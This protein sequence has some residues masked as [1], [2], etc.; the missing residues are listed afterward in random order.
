MTVI[1]KHSDIT[2]K[3][4]I[5][6]C[7]IIGLAL[8]VFEWYHEAGA[9]VLLAVMGYFLSR[10]TGKRRTLFKIV[11][12]ATSLCV[13]VAINRWITHTIVLENVSGRKI[14]HLTVNASVLESSNMF[15]LNNIPD[16]MV[17]SW[18]FRTLFFGG[19]L[20]VQGGFSWTGDLRIS[21]GT[22]YGDHTY[23]RFTHILIHKGGEVSFLRE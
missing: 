4:C 17:F 3:I 2:V 10:R 22:D 18:S 20:G 21:G 6:A 16:G 9:A 11:Y 19:G 15:S 14:A 23:R 7:S 1:E 8:V 13:V 5:V 12:I